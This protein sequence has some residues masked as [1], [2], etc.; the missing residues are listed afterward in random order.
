MSSVNFFVIAIHYLS[1]RWRRHSYL[2]CRKFLTKKLFL[3]CV[4][5]PP[6]SKFSF[7]LCGFSKIPI[8]LFIVFLI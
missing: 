8:F 6:L 3:F 4:C 2:Y 5:K 1:A 7:L